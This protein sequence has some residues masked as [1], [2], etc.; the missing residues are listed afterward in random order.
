[1]RIA[2]PHRLAAVLCLVAVSLAGCGRRGPLELPDSAAATP[3]QAEARQ[4]AQQRALQ[5]EDQPGLIQS[6]N[7]AYEQPAAAK[8]NFD[9]NKNPPRPINAPQASR[10]GTF[11]LDP[12]L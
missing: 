9:T 8:L 11:V 6:P 12:L 4:A 5:T 1:M 7:K 10:P 3:A 2:R